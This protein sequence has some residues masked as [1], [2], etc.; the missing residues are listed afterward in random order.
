MNII[1]LLD[2]AFFRNA[3]LGSFFASIACGIIGTY[4][5]TKR[6][7]FISGGIT[8]ASLGGLGIGFYFSLS[9]ILSAMVFSIFS[10]FGIQWLSQKQGVREDSAIAVFWS[11]GM[12][13][14]IVLTFLTPGYAPN[15]SEY[16]FGNILT[17][18]R[19]DITALLVLSLILLLF[20]ILFYHAIVS[21][22]F[23]TEFAQTRRL[24]T[25]FI[26]YAM[27]LFI[28]V[29]IVLSIRLVGIVLLMS[30]ITVPQM[31]ANLFTVNYSKI[32]SLSILLSFTGCV[33]GLLL[34]YYLNVP[35]GAF[36]IFVLIMMFFIAKAIKVVTGKTL[37]TA[38][39]E[40]P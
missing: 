40:I 16:L 24:P 18:T 35:S 21:V 15:L 4:V 26:E 3:L 29:T 31:T 7:V 9:P 11:L 27:M 23:D 22:S 10:A 30:L 5:V 12:A 28:A 8:H 36:I 13:I 14:G 25:Q 39:Q 32:I 1:E 17:I 34:S 37:K 19:S 20:F 6:L 2:Y 33:I 38:P